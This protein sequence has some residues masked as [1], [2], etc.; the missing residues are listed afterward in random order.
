VTNLASGSGEALKI[1]TEAL[2]I[3]VF[4][5]VIHARFNTKTNKNEEKMAEES[6]SVFLILNTSLWSEAV[7]PV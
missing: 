2:P 1:A 6:A 3:I 7:G 4:S 5:T